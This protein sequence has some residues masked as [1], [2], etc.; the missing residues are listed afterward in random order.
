MLTLKERTILQAAGEVGDTGG[1]CTPVGAADDVLIAHAP[2]LRSSSTPR[3]A[4]V[5][6]RIGGAVD[7]SSLGWRRRWRK[8]KGKRWSGSRGRR[9]TF[10][11][12][13]VL[14][15]G[16]RLDAVVSGSGVPTGRRGSVDQ[17]ARK[18]N[19]DKPWSRSSPAIFVGAR[20]KRHLVT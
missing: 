10:A 7:D 5:W 6:L 17:A 16:L 14:V 4:Y 11:G 19:G 3:N 13:L 2:V 20:E 15:L 8:Q 18:V 1:R 9:V 12:V